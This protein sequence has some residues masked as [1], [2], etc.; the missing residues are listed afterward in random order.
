MPDTTQ[1]VIAGIYTLLRRPSEL[2]LHPDDVLELLNDDLRGRVQ[3]LDLGG[4]DQRTET[5]EV[6]IDP[7]DIDYLI[8]L[9]NVPDFE[10]VRLE[11]GLTANNL[12]A[13]W[14]ANVVS[15]SAWAQHFDSDRLAAS[16]TGSFAMQEGVKVRLNIDPSQLGNYQWRL[17]Y[18][19][20]LLN[21]VQTGDRPPIPTN[22][23]PM[24]KLS[25]AIKAMSI[26]KDS[27]DEW[28]AWM[29]RTLP[30]FS[31]DLQRWEE[32]WDQYVNSSVEPPTQP[33]RPWNSF[34]QRR[35][36]N[37]RAYLPLR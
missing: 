4:R 25:V 19:L 12:Q 3:D 32:R 16:F 33:I 7:D 17:T 31:A 24:L 27:T 37:P 29:R 20:P 23:L 10:P 8:R 21:I 26:V 35:V 5:A 15:P 22:F 34:R 13:W 18:R 28:V 11:Y 6:T 14:E 2:K 30:I 36:R 9:P 1:Q